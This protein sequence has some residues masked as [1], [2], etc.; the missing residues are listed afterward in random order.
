MSDGNA[1]TFRS[2]SLVQPPADLRPVSARPN[3]LTRFWSMIV[4]SKIP[5]ARPTVPN[6]AGFPFG[7]VALLDFY[8][9]EQPKPA[10]LGSATGFFIRHDLLIT[11]AHNI[12][13]SGADMIAT[14][15]G[16]DTKLN[17]SAMIAA[18]RWV[19]ST[20]RDV[21]IILTRPG[22]PVTVTLGPPMSPSAMLVGYASNYQDGTKRMSSGSGQC[23]VKG[24]QCTYGIAAQQGDSGGPI[25]SSGNTAMALHT[26]LMAGSNGTMIGGGETADAQFMS[27]VASLEAQVRSG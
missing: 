21:S 10:Y 17:Q 5:D 23:Q 15:P 18:V 9:D 7:A 24:Q 4:G 12:Y 8:R 14:F 19:Q 27:I 26:Q 2:K 3:L 20:A 11:A 25:F 16:W 13:Y 1:E 6:P 22:A